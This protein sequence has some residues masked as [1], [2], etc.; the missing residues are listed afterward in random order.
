MDKVGENARRAADMA[1]V[2]AGQ[3]GRLCCARTVNLC[4]WW[5]RS[6][7]MASRSWAA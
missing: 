2:A 1:P 7:K 3:H 6:C 4:V 5:H